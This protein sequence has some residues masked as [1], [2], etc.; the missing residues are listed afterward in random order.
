MTERSLATAYGNL[1]GDVAAAVKRDFAWPSPEAGFACFVFHKAGETGPV[2]V[3]AS[4]NWPSGEGLVHAPSL[5]AAGYWLACGEGSD[6]RSPWLDGVQRLSL[7]DAFPSDRQSFVYR[8]I[9]LLGLVLGI[10]ACAGTASGLAGW[11]KGVFD[12]IRKEQ[13]PDLWSRCLRYG[14]EVTLGLPT[15]VP[16]ELNTGTLEEVGL[17]RWVSRSLGKLDTTR[18]TDET[19]LRR[20]L[21]ETAEGSDLARNAVLYQALRSGIADTIESEVE[22]HWQVGRRQRD[23]EALVITLC[24]RFHL[25]A[26]ELLDRHDNRGTVEVAD[27]YD[28]QDLM[29]ALLKLHFED[30]RAEEVTPSMGGKSGRMDF[31]LKAERLVVETKM[32]RKGLDQKAV[33][34]ELIVDMKRYRSHPDY[35]TLVC[36]VYDPSGLCHAPAALENDLGGQ[37]G[38]F[39]IVIVVCPRGM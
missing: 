32:T 2:P 14:A 23:A 9:E 22:Q 7:R 31:L 6:I 35:R 16:M 38:E 27:E 37:E 12:R 21:L 36:F 24:R 29:H 15:T 11:I 3:P 1:L 13:A 28:V 5:A 25:F 8:P 33:G 20:A 30:V 18:E 34:D 10:T 39:R 26:Q 4:L 17:V 19:L